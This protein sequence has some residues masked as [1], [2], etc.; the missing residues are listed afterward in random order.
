MGRSL[1]EEAAQPTRRHP[2][3]LEADRA[4]AATKEN[5]E[6]WFTRI[7]TKIDPKSVRPELVFN[8]DET[9]IDFNNKKLRVVAPKDRAPIHS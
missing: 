1:G 5:L 3:P 2:R 6:E 9:M 8:M 7:N 4:H